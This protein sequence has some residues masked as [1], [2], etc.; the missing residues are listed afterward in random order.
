MN[1]CYSCKCWHAHRSIGAGAGADERLVLAHHGRGAAPPLSAAR[2]LG[3][4]GQ[5]VATGERDAADEVDVEGEPQ[6]LQRWVRPRL[7]TAGEIRE[8]PA[9]PF[10][11]AR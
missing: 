6:G 9:S 7:H 8:K 3:G 1:R 2:A 11:T 5:G 4:S 10:M